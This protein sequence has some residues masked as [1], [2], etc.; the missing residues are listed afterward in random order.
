MA[1]ALK[2]LIIVQLLIGIGAL[3]LG[4]I[5]FSQREVLKKRV[6]QLEDGVEAVA[7]SIRFETFRK[8]SLVVNDKSGLDPQK[9]SLAL[10]AAAG[11][12]QWTELQDTK[13]D[14]ENTRSD[15]EQ[16][17]TE[18]ANTKSQLS[19]ARD[20]IAQLEQ[21]VAQREA[22]LAQ[23]NGRIDTLETEA[24]ALQAE[25]D[26]LTAKVAELEESFRECEANYDSLLSDFKK[27]VGEKT[28]VKGLAGRI[29]FVNP[30]W[31]FVILDIGSDEGI[32]ATAEMLVQ[33]SD[34]LVGRVRVTTVD[35][36]MSVA[37]IIPEWQEEAVRKG[38][39]VISPES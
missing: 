4:S 12:N 23:A 13:Q 39:Y 16:T 31:N 1:K 24:T 11:Q 30:E 6:Q 17:R 25:I 27:L 20:Q 37:E 19:D 2:A 29:L 15:L 3:V 10:V 14:L 36:S 8:D 34:K 28:N 9:N 21:T 33:R 7:K 26:S 35:N 18:L 5:L 38:D 32:S 22:D